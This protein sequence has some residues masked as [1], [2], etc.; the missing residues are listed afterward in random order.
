VSIEGRIREIAGQADPASR[1]YAVRVAM[2]GSPQIMRLGMTAS[3]ALRIDDEVADLVVPLTALTKSEGGPEV[4][5]VDPTNKAVHKAPVSVGGIAEDGVRITDGLHAG[6]LVVTAGVQF[7]RDGMRVRLPDER[8]HA[9][10]RSS[11]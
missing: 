7:L 5:V 10:S 11:S 6:Q 8:Q 4:F 9:R 1:T 2:S 3:V